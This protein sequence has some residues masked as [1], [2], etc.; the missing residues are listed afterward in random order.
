MKKWWKERVVY[1]IYPRSFNDTNQDGIGDIRGVIDKLDV[2]HKLGIGI[3]WFSP[4]Y[5]SPNK[6]YGYDVADYYSIHP[7][8]GSMSDMDDLIEKATALDIKIV[9]DMVVNHTSDR[10]EWFIKSIQGIEPYKDYYIWRDGKHK[11]YPNNWTSFFTGPAWEY[12]E[13]RNQYYLHLFAKEQPD[14]NWEN[15]KVREEV[16]NIMRFWLNKGISGFRCDVINII[17]KSGFKDGKWKPALKGLEH[18]LTQPNMHEHLKELRRDVLQHYDCFTVGETILVTPKQAKELCD[19]ELDMV[20]SFEHMEVDQYLVKWFKRRFSPYR[21][22][23]ALSKWQTGVEWNANYFENH[24]QLRSVSRFGDDK[25][26][27]S[28]SAKMLATLLLSLRGTPFIYQ[29]QEIGMTNF[30]FTSMNEIL[31]VDSHNVDTML[32][33]VHIPTYFRWKKIRRTSRDNV[34]TPMQWNTEINGGFTNG[35]PWLG[36]N[37]NYKRIN[38]KSQV[39]EKDSIWNFYRKM[40]EYR[41]K[42]EC[43]IYGEFKELFLSKKVFVF[44]RAMADEAR[45]MAFNFSSKRFKVP[46]S[47]V[48]EMDNYNKAIFDGVLEPYQGVIFKNQ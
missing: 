9:M 44:R 40:I 31:D 21:F 33:K 20:F 39:H 13:K 27:W 35:T 7:E 25:L 15:P 28:K 8:Y 14:L 47:G 30:D 16:K 46:Y 3:I 19:N 23:K 29:G 38:V 5:D 41:S 1:Q 4:L 11:N 45:Y 2:L 42:N 10:H 48:T 22:F 17:S 24:D 26:Y 37:K 36:V 18:Y 43:L 34:R 6:D 12:S 32:K